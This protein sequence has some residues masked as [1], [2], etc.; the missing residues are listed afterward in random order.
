VSE[1]EKREEK[2]TKK[3]D[4]PKEEKKRKRTKTESK[5]EKKPINGVSHPVPPPL[6]HMKKSRM[7]CSKCK[8]PLSETDNGHCVKC[9]DMCIRCGLNPPARYDSRCEDCLDFA[10]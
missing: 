6:P 10:K 4:E 1:E 7:V 9:D 8:S 3:K 2:K 5:E